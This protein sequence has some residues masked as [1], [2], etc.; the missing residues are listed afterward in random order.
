MET[1]YYDA[2]IDR[3]DQGIQNQIMKECRTFFPKEVLDDTSTFKD[4]ILMPYPKIKKA[5]KAINTKYH[6]DMKKTCFHELS[7]KNLVPR[8]HYKL[9]VSMYTK[10]AGD[11][12]VGKSMRVRLVYS[13]G[14]TVCPYCNRDY[15]NA[16]GGKVSGAQ[17]DHFY[18][19][20]SYPFLSLSLYNLIPVCGNCNRVKSKKKGPFASVFDTDI[21]FDSSLTFD[22]NDEVTEIQ[23]NIA[24]GRVELSNN[25]REMKIKEA[26]QLHTTEVK[27]LLE[28]ENAYKET[29]LW[30]IRNTLGAVRISDE[31]I[32]R[33]IFGPRIEEKDIRKKPLGKMMKDLHKK[34][35][36][37]S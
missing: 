16:R 28:L 13:L 20:D 1:D 8:D 9:L 17:L 22:Y 29:Q 3:V 36:I 5:I 18:N 6:N 21:D 7:E 33:I 11:T 31:Q 14:L 25:I 15:I 23:L 32:K 10:V 2:V 34:L 12:S 24:D 27:E 37:Y 35:K 4:L 30:E 26:Y 19:K